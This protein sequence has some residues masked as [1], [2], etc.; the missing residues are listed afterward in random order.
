MAS[1]TGAYVRPTT[2]YGITYSAELKIAQ[3][4][5]E[6]LLAHIRGQEEK[7]SR[8]SAELAFER[9]TTTRLM[10]TIRSLEE[11]VKNAAGDA[12]R[13]KA[14]ESELT[15][16]KYKHSDAVCSRDGWRNKLRLERVAKQWVERW[17]LLIFIILVV[18]FGV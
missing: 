5:I 6:A 18:S 14:L 1:F 16:W 11:D 13:I 12:T 15:R 2:Q 3:K 10:A 4:H 9:S 8:V 7:I 17:C